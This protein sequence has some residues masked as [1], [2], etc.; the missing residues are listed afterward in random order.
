MKMIGARPT[1]DQG[2]G[3]EAINDRHVHV[4][5]HH[6]KLLRQQITQRLHPR[7]GS[8]NVQVHPGQ[9]RRQRGEVGRAVIHNQ[10]AHRDISIH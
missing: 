1:A 4:E 5:Q 8:H 9:R 2:G 3:L 10:D 7:G 6:R